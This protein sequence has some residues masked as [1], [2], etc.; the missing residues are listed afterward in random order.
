SDQYPYYYPL[1]NLSGFWSS[2]HVVALSKNNR[3]HLSSGGYLFSEQSVLGVRDEGA[4]IGAIPRGL[5]NVT[6]GNLATRIGLYSASGAGPTQALDLNYNSLEPGE[7]LAG[8]AWRLS[9]EMCVVDSQSSWNGG[10][11]TVVQPDG[12]RIPFTYQGNFGAY[13]ADVDT[14]VY[15]RIERQGTADNPEYKLTTKS[16]DVLW[17]NS[18][19]RLRQI[20]DPIGN[21][22]NLTYD[23]QVVGGV[24]V[25][26]LI[27]ISDMN[28]QRNTALVYEGANPQYGSR[29]TQITDP[30][31]GSYLLSYQGR[32]LSTV[33]FATGPGAPTYGFE[34]Y[35][36]DDP[37]SGARLGQLS[38]FKTPRAQSGGYF[39]ACLYTPNGRLSQIQDPSENYLQENAS[40]STPPTQQAAKLGLRYADGSTTWLTDRRGVQ[41]RFLGD[42]YRS[43]VF[44]VDDAAALAQDPGITPV[45]RAFDGFGNLVDLQ[46]RWGFRTTYN[47]DY[48]NAV[49][50]YVVDNVLSILR[51]S[52]QSASQ[53]LVA[54]YTYT[55]DGLNRVQT[56]T[57]YATPADGSGPQS[58]TTSFTYNTAGQL[59]TVQ[60]PDVMIS[61]I[62]SQTA[63]QS[64]FEYGGPLGQL[65]RSVNEN[66][67]GV[68]YSQFDGACGLPQSVLADG[69][70]DP[71]LFAYDLLGNLVKKQEPRGSAL[72]D[73]PNWTVL[74]RDGLYRLSSEVDPKGKVTNYAYDVDSNLIQVTPPVGAATLTTYDR[75]GFVSGGSTPDGSYSQWVDAAGNVRRAQDLRGFISNRYFD[76]MGR[77]T[78]VHTPGAST[79]GAGGGGGDP[80]EQTTY[81]Y[82]GFDGAK[83]MSF[84]TQKGAPNDR[85]TRTE[86]DNRGRAARVVEPDLITNHKT[87]YDEL[88]HVVAQQ[89]AFG[90][91][92]EHCIVTFLDARDRAYQVR[93]QDG[94]YGGTST[95]TSSTYTLYDPAGNVAQTVDAL[96][97]FN[98]PGYAH[99]KTYLYD[100]R[101]RLQFEIDGKG[102]MVRANFYG[103]D[104]RIV[105]TRTPDPAS[106]S[107]LL[108]TQ[109]TYTY[110]TRKERLTV[111]DRNGKGMSYTYG[112]L[113]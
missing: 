33:T 24:H 95:R 41:S 94:A 45:V 89:K 79:L 47:L 38:R 36:V 35:P 21:F 25:S 9:A 29:I 11:M 10:R 74:S 61:G 1:T 49:P 98:Q 77:T 55:T 72:N 88:D 78:E 3:L 90:N 75:R 19:G 54:S 100:V 99:K 108:V 63:V 110:S 81:I 51:P 26:H 106:K 40:D 107:S 6:T 80:I 22:M 20:V 8:A 113:A 23:D 52:A 71:R 59:T 58:R 104:D 15:A 43:L 12:R 93:R 101:E 28:G 67:H 69:G 27:Q 65:T 86:Y 44:E 30:E 53:D 62:P 48:G 57:T 91:E 102:V 96:G 13:I 2:Q 34:Y 111:L 7:G 5:V 4:M 68:S 112:D 87:F 64:H 76:F 82:D 16:G 97:Q 42:G 84:M 56:A 60:Y 109:A 105:E 37:A 17:F 92:I 31:G 66:G 32:S 85:V 14:G 73:L 50:S 103:D 70:S 39:W 83:H 46:D 18:S